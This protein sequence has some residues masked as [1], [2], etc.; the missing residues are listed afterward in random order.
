MRSIARK[1]VGIAAGATVVGGALLAGA[2]PAQAYSPNPVPE[3]HSKATYNCPG[4]SGCQ[5]SDVIDGTYFKKD[6]GGKAVKIDLWKSG[7]YIGKVEYHPYG[8]HLYVYDND[9]K[10]TFYVTLS[11]W[12]EENGHPITTGPYQAKTTESDAHRDL[13]HAEGQAIT[14]SVW[15][16]VSGRTGVDRFAR[17]TAIA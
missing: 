16:S 8:E 3:Y 10:D 12:N 4:A 6:A 5:L 14:I 17:A 9:P 2:T 11:Y 7:N 13:S 1:I 15:D